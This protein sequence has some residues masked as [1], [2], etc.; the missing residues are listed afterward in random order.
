MILRVEERA[1]TGELKKHTQELGRRFVLVDKKNNPES[2]LYAVTRAVVDVDTPYEPATVRAHTVD[3]VM[4]F[5]GFGERL[6][7][8]RA[9]VT[10]NGEKFAVDSPASVYVPAGVNHL[11]KILRGSGT[12]TKIV[13]AP[14]GDYNDVTS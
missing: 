6:E 11:Y 12:Y 7:G 14:G 10:L 4:I 5:M 2:K 9:E 13:L 1:A 8:L 3:A